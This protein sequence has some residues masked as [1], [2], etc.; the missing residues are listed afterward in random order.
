MPGYFVSLIAAIFAEA[1]LAS[2]TI[3][4]NLHSAFGAITP[5]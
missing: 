3:A 2:M 1:A 4:R 5:V